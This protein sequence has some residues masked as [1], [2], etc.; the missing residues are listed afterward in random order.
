MATA[1]S[2]KTA[3]PDTSTYK[4]KLLNLFGEVASWKIR[5]TGPELQSDNLAKN[6]SLMQQN[7]SPKETDDGARIEIPLTAEEWEH[8][9]QPRRKTLVVKLMGK[10]VNFKVL[11]SNLQ[12]KWLKKGSIKVVDM[13]DGYFLV[14]FYPRKIILLHL[15]KVLGELHIII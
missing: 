11:E 7:L 8:C 4:D 6:D 13:S 10:S 9:S 5:N 3:I 2:E 14:Y 15:L 12:K 1:N